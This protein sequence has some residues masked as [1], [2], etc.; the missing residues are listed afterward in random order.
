MS[1]LKET[2]LSHYDCL[3]I[4]S[5]PRPRS[6]VHLPKDYAEVLLSHARLHVFAE[7]YD[8]QS[9]KQLSHQRVLRTLNNYTLYPE[10]LGNITILIK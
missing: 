7:K 1:R 6:N 3:D 2:F 8:T 10:C 9:L 5:L 4:E